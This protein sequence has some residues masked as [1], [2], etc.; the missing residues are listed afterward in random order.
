MIARTLTTHGRILCLTTAL[1]AGCVNSS[2]S[3]D[4]GFDLTLRLRDDLQDLFQCTKL[5]PEP[6]R[7]EFQEQIWRDEHGQRAVAPAR[8]FTVTYV[9]QG[10]GDVE[11]G[12]RTV[13]DTWS[14]LAEPAPDSEPSQLE[15]DDGSVLV[16]S[17]EE[18]L[19]ASNLD[20]FCADYS[21]SWR[22]VAGE[23]D[24][25]TGTFR[26]INDSV[27]IVLHLVEN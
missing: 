16:L 26:M 22:G 7:I 6:C 10:H 27:Q 5:Q 2:C 23:L 4:R 11:C 21:G 24:E 13:E 25:R 12:N 3:N 17:E 14:Y 9:R 20:D 18:G 19:Q 15:L 1:L 8:N